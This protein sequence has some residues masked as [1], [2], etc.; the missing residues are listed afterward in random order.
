MRLILILVKDV[1]CQLQINTWLS[2]NLIHFHSQLLKN[3]TFQFKI[4]CIFSYDWILTQ[5]KW[6]GVCICPTVCW[7][8]DKLLL[9]HL[10]N[11]VPLE[12]LL[13]ENETPP[14]PPRQT[15]LKTLLKS[16]K[17]QA[18]SCRSSS[19]HLT[20]P[21][22]SRRTRYWFVFFLSHSLFHRVLG[23]QQHSPPTLVALKEFGQWGGWSGSGGV[24]RQP[25]LLMG[26]CLANNKVL[27]LS[28]VS[29]TP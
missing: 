17:T 7:V 4:V 9:F 29:T 20:A 6:G 12:G 16:T 23:C 10:R 22:N 13:G 26:S 8:G 28:S 1:F 14:S 15:P 25:L 3:V 18:E 24:F 27:E 21:V 5:D 19:A 2:I 11:K